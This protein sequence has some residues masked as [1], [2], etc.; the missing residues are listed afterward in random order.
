MILIVILKVS[1]RVTEG[2][3]EAGFVVEIRAMVGGDHVPDHSVNC[4]D[5]YFNIVI[6]DFIKNFL[7]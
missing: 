2:M 7:V 3:V 1:D 5:M 6:I 4:V